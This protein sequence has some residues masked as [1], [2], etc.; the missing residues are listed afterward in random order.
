[1]VAGQGA[2]GKVI[3]G[4]IPS[5]RGIT[6]GTLAGTGSVLLEP[7]KG[8]VSYRGALVLG[9]GAVEVCVVVG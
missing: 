7:R 3:L 5:Y 8:M 6:P 1:M 2:S 9:I 4:G